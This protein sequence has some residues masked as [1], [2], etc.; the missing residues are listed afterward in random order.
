M[1]IHTLHTERCGVPVIAKLLQ[2]RKILFSDN[3]LETAVV[4]LKFPENM[5]TY[6]VSE[7]QYPAFLKTD[8]GSKNVDVLQDVQINNFIST[9]FINLREKL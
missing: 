1:L 2:Q 5:A 8:I 4:V 6:H 9:S 7:S 3:V